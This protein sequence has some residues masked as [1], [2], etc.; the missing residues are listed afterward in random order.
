MKLRNLKMASFVGSSLTTVQAA[1]NDFT[2]G[3]ALTSGAS[4][5][6]AYAAGFAGERTFQDVQYVFDGTNHAVAIFY[7]E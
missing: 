7:T 5:T 2:A 4:G 1:V 6:V 3:K